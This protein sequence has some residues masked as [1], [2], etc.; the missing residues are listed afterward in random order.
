MSDDDHLPPEDKSGPWY[1]PSS[2]IQNVPVLGVVSAEKF[3]L[4]ENAKPTEYLP[5]FMDKAQR[6]VALRVVGQCMMPTVFDGEYAVIALQD[7]AENGQLVVARINQECTLKRYFQ[8]ED[9]F[10]LRPD[11]PTYKTIVI[12]NKSELDIIGVVK[13]FTRRV[14]TP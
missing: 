7:K 8:V 6:Y 10:E 11:N 13:F 5:I 2:E 14:A 4:V 9:H 3:T 1:V 12:K